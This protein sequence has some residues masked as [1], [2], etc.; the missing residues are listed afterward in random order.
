M[1]MQI[2]KNRLISTCYYSTTSVIIK[3]HIT[4]ILYNFK[5]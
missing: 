5:E 2:Y 4:Y 1:E 3:I